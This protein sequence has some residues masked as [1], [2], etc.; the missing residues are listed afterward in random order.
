V[1]SAVTNL[2]RV[3]A[4]KVAVAALVVVTV[5]IVLAVI[6]KILWIQVC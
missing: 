6:T 4:K 2:K 5:S 1:V 3:K